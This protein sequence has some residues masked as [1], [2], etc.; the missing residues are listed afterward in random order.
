[1]GT[2]RERT[3]YTRTGERISEGSIPAGE[4]AITLTVTDDDATATDSATIVVGEDTG[5]DD[6]GTSLAY[7]SAYRDQNGGANIP[8]GGSARGV[9]SAFGQMQRDNDQYAQFNDNRDTLAVGVAT[10]GIDRSGS[11]YVLE[12]AYKYDRSSGNPVYAVIV[13]GSG[14]VL[15]YQAL[16]VSSNRRTTSIALNENARS[17]V[18]N[19]G[20]LYVQYYSSSNPPNLHLYYQRLRVT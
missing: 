15:Q 11:N 17:Y 5:N 8:P 14:N 13:D 6:T 2:H 16:Q 9:L 20:T 19:T 4:Y 10:S 12:L 7:P 3:G 1:M 18:Q